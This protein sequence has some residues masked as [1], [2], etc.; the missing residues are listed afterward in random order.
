MGFMDKVKATGGK[1]GEQAKHGIEQGQQKLDDVKEKRK[2][3]ALLHDLGAAVFYDRTGKGTPAITADIERLIS[4]LR[5][6][7]EEGSVIEPPPPA[8]GSPDWP[9]AQ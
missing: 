6:L 9:S 1:V 4:E 3:D 5:K 8:T 2:A 7:E